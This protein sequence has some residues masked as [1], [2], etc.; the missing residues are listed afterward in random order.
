MNDP[1]NQKYMAARAPDLFAGQPRTFSIEIF[2]PKTEEGLQKLHGT[3]S[4][5]C[6]LRPDFISCTYGA[7][8]GSRDK[9]FDIAQHIQDK[10]GCLAV[11]HLTCV[12][13][14]RE[15][16]LGILTGIKDRGLRN[17]LA[18]RGDP[19]KDNPGWTPG[20][21]NFR[22]SSELVKFIRDHFSGHFGIGVAGF[23][24][25]HVLCRDREQD[26]RY[27][28]MKIDSGADFVITQLFFNN[29]DYFDYVKRLRRIG[30]TARVIPGIL[31]VTDYHGLV[32]FCGNCGTDITDE[33]KKIFEPIQD[34]K[35]KI[36]EEGIRFAVRQC[37]ELLDG[38]AP[39]LHFYSLNRVHPVDE[40]LKQVRR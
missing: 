12:C 35:D 40:I 14:T 13:H 18:L 11:A 4:E 28:K 27:L 10:H 34:D 29:Q 2:P 23:P 25:G 5:L 3:I 15:E 7:G 8:G 30:V 33:V 20:E 37:R 16:L 22:Y 31:P 17:V 1:F 39:G 24:E 38:G 21:H 32:R 26:A 6:K 36:L 9:T 19:P